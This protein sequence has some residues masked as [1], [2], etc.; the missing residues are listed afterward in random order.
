MDKV[1]S[2]LKNSIAF[3]YL[4]DVIIP[5]KTIEEGMT[6]LRQVLDTYKSIN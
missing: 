3:P 2:N 5:S 4:G 6:R 1:L